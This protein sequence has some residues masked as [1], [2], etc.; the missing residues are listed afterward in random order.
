MPGYPRFASR[1]LDANLGEKFSTIAFC[2][3][4]GNRLN[5]ERLLS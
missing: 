4:G 2:C 5:V 3:R 1:F